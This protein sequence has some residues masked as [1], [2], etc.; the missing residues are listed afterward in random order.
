M[1]THNMYGLYVVFV[2]VVNVLLVGAGDLRHILRTVTNNHKHTSK[3]LHVSTATV[4]SHTS[5]RLN[6]TC[7]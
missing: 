5:V 2:D 7:S 4:P 6:I 1:G 3:P